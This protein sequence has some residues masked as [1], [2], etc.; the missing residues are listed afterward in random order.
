MR[1]NMRA[2][3]ARIGLSAR[4]TAKEIG[5]SENT[6]LSWET[7][8]KEPLASNLLKLSALYGCSPEY[9]LGITVER[10]KTKVATA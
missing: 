7:G 6:L 4:E 2:E 8:D 5:V 3:R 10:K 1:G 9:L